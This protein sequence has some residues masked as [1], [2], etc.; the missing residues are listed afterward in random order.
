MLFAKMAMVYQ[1]NEITVAGP[2]EGPPLFL[3]QTEVGRAEKFFL[4][5]PLV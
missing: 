1:H 5:T 3:D 4:Q 2:G